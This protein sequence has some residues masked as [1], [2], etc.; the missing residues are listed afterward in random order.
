LFALIGPNAFELSG[1]RAIVRW[2]CP[3]DASFY[4]TVIPLEEYQARMGELLLLI[5][6]RTGLPLAELSQSAR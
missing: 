1:P 6:R 4:D 2:T 3:T 5:A